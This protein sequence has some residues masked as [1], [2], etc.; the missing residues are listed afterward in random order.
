[1]AKREKDGWL[2]VF[3]GPILVFLSLCALWKN[4]T[5]FDY[6]R[7]ASKIELTT[8]LAGVEQGQPLAYTGVMDPESVVFAGNYVQQFKGYLIVYREAEI[9]AWDRDED[10][11]GDVTWSRKWMSSVESN[12]RNNGIRQELS[13]KTFLPTKFEIS[14]LTVESQQV[15]FVDSTQGIPPN[16]LARTEA[17]SR[18]SAEGSYFFLR[19]GRSDNLGDER[20]SYRAIPVPRTAT[21]FGKYQDAK[22]VADRSHERTNFINKIIQDTGILH[23][24]VAGEREQAL[25]TMKAY[26]SRLKWIVRGIGT[27]LVVFGFFFTFSK[28]LGFLFHIPLI[29]PLAE[30]GTFAISLGLGLP[31][32]LLTIA[33]GYLAGHPVVLIIF[34]CLLGGGIYFLAKTS[35]RGRETQRA[36]RNELENEFG[37][38]VNSSELKEREFVGL[39]HLVSSGKSSDVGAS[40]KL[41]DDWSRKHKWDDNKKQS[42]LAKAAETTKSSPDQELRNL[43]RI[44]I[45]DGKLTPFEMRSILTAAANAGYDR[46]Q[47]REMMGTLKRS[48]KLRSNKIE[49]QAS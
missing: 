13:S 33:A 17:G 43:I 12:S 35:R 36:M 42:M 44:A 41:L 34:L 27:A 40:S 37:H 21:Y 38:Q 4:E 1:M 10:S 49:S 23:H 19:K 30:A 28:L 9:Y 16:N 29:G 47:V 39:A 31:L 48:A 18:L 46:N 26:L 15:E 5:R 22:G 7:A 6:Y 14:E 2:G 25:A 24:I 8:D 45:A 20:L 11:D 3:I 32:A